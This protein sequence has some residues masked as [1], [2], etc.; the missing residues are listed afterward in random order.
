VTV[1]LK[2][3]HSTYPLTMH[4][5]ELIRTQI[6][7]HNIY[8]VSIIINITPTVLFRILVKV[9]AIGKLVLLT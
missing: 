6:L 5:Y 2:P 7:E 1:P 8:H 3:P 9:N 4:E